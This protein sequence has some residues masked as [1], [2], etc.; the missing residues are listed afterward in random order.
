[1]TRNEQRRD[2]Q[3]QG[4][5]RQREGVKRM[6]VE[7]GHQRELSRGRDAGRGGLGEGVYT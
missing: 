2:E 3:V 6:N 1:V 7:E 4:E 5:Q